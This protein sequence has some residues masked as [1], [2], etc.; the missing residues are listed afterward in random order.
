MPRAHLH[1]RTTARAPCGCWA[2]LF[3]FPKGLVPWH[4]TTACQ[5]ASATVHASGPGRWLRGPVRRALSATPVPA[6]CRCWC[7]K[8]PAGSSASRTLPLVT[9][10][11]FVPYKVHGRKLKEGAQ[12]AAA[13]VRGR[14]N[15]LGSAPR[16]EFDV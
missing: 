15:G 6:P 1:P 10:V 16:E 7:N 13:W 4:G 12:R 11:R 8:K 3:E 9:L 14:T 5:R 2:T